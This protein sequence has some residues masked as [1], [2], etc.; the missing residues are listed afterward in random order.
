VK[1]LSIK[2][3]DDL[4]HYKRKDWSPPWIKLYN[5]LLDDYEFLK[6][7]ETAQRH[8]ICLWLLASRHNNRIPND[9]VHIT[10]A[11]H[12]KSAVDL[13]ELILTGFVIPTDEP[14]ARKVKRRKKKAPVPASRTI[15]E[16]VYK[17]STPEKIR[18]EKSR[19]DKK[20]TAKYPHFPV[21]VS[22]RLYAQWADDVGGSGPAEFRKALSECFPE[23]G[24]LYTEAQLGGAIKVF[25]EYRSGLSPKE[26]RFN[27]IYTLRDDIKR[28]VH[29]GSMPAQLEDGTPTER[30]RVVLGQVA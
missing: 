14:P 26:A 21:P 9:L 28:W 22:N 27:T 19:E 4:Q 2:S 25:G 29:L 7:S 8:L 15:S 10:R 20:P 18:K 23:S 17:E 3:F 13:D 5:R 30:G 6:L 12:A 16:G 1:Y 24:P 11:I